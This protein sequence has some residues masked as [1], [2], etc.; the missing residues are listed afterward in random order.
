MQVNM[1][2]LSEHPEH[3]RTLAEWHHQ[4]GSYLNPGRTSRS[5]RCVQVRLKHSALTGGMRT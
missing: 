2:Y 4:Q 1:V 3:L 5:C